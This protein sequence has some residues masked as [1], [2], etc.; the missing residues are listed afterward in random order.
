MSRL[1]AW[2]RVAL[3][4][5]S[6][7]SEIDI[8]KVCSS[9][10]DLRWPS[11]AAKPAR[12]QP[13][14]GARFWPRQVEMTRRSLSIIGRL[15]SISSQN[16]SKPATFGR[17]SPNV[18]RNQ[19]NFGRNREN[20]ADGRILA[21]I[22]QWVETGDRWSDM[23]QRCSK[24]AT[25]GR[26]RS[27]F[28]RTQP[29]IGRNQPKS[30]LN[31]TPEFGRARPTCVDGAQNSVEPSP[32]SG[33]GNAGGGRFSEYLVN[34]LGCLLAQPSWGH[35]CCSGRNLCAVFGFCSQLPSLRCL[36]CVAAGAAARRT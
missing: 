11:R 5:M 9:W 30:V 15:W 12:P 19:H 27:N 17:A 18:G 16:W 10:R 29:K 4:F 32:N 2:R 20:L 21:E 24:P 14:P 6:M 22:G 36:G 26:I 8:Y 1:M 34:M 31:I 23:A 33:G 35:R 13:Q 3:N 25:F 28:G 7:R